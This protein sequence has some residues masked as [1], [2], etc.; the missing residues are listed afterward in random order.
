MGNQFYI[1]AINLFVKINTKDANTLKGKIMSAVVS[2]VS[3]TLDKTKAY[4]SFKDHQHKN[5]AY[6]SI[7]IPFVLLRGKVF[8]ND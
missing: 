6:D 2:T 5:I 7:N 3:I 8:E 4:L 1:T